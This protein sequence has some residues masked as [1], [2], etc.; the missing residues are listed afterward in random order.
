MTLLAATYYHEGRHQQQYPLGCQRTSSDMI[1]HVAQEMTSYFVGMTH[2]AD[3]LPTL[4][5]HLSIDWPSD[6]LV[7]AQQFKE[8][9]IPGDVSKAFNH[10]VK[11]GQIWAFLIGIVLGY[12]VKTFT[13]YG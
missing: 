1:I 6:W 12:L 7:L 3:I 8:P 9:D 4:H 10:F 5:G 13:S 2:P 11:T